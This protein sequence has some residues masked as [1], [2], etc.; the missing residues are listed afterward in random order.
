MTNQT[1]SKSLLIPILVGIGIG[2]LI[3]GLLPGMGSSLEFLGELF[4]NGLLMLVIGQIFTKQK[5]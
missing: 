3:G 5:I 4:I 2:I 1:Q